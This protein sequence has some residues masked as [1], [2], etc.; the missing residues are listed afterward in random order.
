MLFQTAATRR[1][2]L[3]KR[4]VK[5]STRAPNSR[6]QDGVSISRRH[7]HAKR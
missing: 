1:R 7:P 4:Q 3:T 5:L 2:R 6:K